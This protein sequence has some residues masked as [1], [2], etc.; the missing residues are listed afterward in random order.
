[1]R[2]QGCQLARGL[3]RRKPPGAHDGAGNAPGPAFFSIALDHGH[4][5]RFVQRVEQVCCG[6]LVSPIHAHI[7]GSFTHEAKT[8]FGRFE[9]VG[10]D[11]EVEKNTVDGRDVE[12]VQDAP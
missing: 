5:A 1:L 6:L 10:R 7:Q 12:P 4:Q 11:P 3:Q 8:P 9:L 2:D